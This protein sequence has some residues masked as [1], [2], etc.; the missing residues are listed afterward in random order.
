M[1]LISNRGRFTLGNEKNDKNN[2]V[3]E[4]SALSFIGVNPKSIFNIQNDKN[5]KDIKDDLRKKINSNSNI[6][7]ENSDNHIPSHLEYNIKLNK[8]SEKDIKIESDKTH[9]K[10]VVSKKTKLFTIILMIIVEIITLTGIYMLGSVYRYLSLT[11]EI[12]FD[13]KKVENVNLDPITIEKMKGFKTVAIFG[14]DSRTGSV[15]KGNNSDVNIIANLNLETGEIQLVSVYRDLYL[16]ITDDNLFGKLN[17]A[18]LKGGPEQ[19]VKVIN[20]NF[21]ININSYFAFNWKAVADGI[22]LLGGIDIEVTKSEYKYLNAFIHETC[23]ATGIDGKNPAAH[24]VKSYGYQ[25]LDGVQAV[26]YGRL[27]LM[28]SDFQR[29][30]RQKKI[31]G[32][33]LEKAKKIDIPTLR[34]IIEAVLPQIGY[35]YDMNEIFSLLKLVNVA[36]ITDSTGCPDV[37]SVRTVQMGSNGDCV[38]PLNLQKSVTLLHKVLFNVDNYNPSSSVKHYSN[39]ITELRRK[40][41][42]ENKLKGQSEESIDGEIQNEVES[43]GNSTVKQTKKRVATSSNAKPSSNKETTANSN[44]PISDAESLVEEPE[45][46]S[47]PIS[48]N[49]NNNNNSFTEYVSP[50]VP[51]NNNN[52]S[53][54]APGGSADLGSTPG[55]SAPGNSAPGGSAPGGSAPSNQGNANQAVAVPGP[56]TENMSPNNTNITPN[57]QPTMAQASNEVVPIIGAPF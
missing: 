38:V 9:Y 20:K 17:A 52:T 14:V 21:D 8:K 37:S 13:P 24:Y 50:G 33:C 53:N 36:R 32:L 10:K 29:V 56:P 57:T 6:D 47:L 12:D 1:S 54:N 26:A 41:E 51:A 49:N 4:N 18:Y 5:D 31:I 30:E 34:M 23:I 22:Q 42:E 16:S 2:N 27:R 39:R 44:L 43:E 40:H 11:Q 3:E 15:G 7:V 55:G 25:H 28:D 46:D 35:S 48:N 45:S 19:A